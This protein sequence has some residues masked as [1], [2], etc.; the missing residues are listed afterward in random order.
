MLTIYLNIQYIRPFVL[1]WTD[2]EEDKPELFL[3]FKHAVKLA[4]GGEDIKTQITNK[5]I[6]CA[7]CKKERGY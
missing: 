2:E 4:S 5:D 7:I 3:C 6:V 1:A